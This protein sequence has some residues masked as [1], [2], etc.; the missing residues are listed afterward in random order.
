LLG[1]ELGLDG[2]GRFKNMD[3][4]VVDGEDLDIPTFV[5]LGVNIEKQTKSR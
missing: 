3:P 1:L 2:R 5:R 4:T